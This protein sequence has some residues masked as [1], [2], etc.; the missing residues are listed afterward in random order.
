MQIE[1]IEVKNLDA[2]K[3]VEEKAKYHLYISG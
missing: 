2:Q 1:E 3:F